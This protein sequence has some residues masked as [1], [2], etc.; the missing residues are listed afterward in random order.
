[1][2]DREQYYILYTANNNYICFTAAGILCPRALLVA[3]DEQIVNFPLGISATSQKN[4]SPTE[5]VTGKQCT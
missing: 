5:I 2:E 1:M 4:E 3:L